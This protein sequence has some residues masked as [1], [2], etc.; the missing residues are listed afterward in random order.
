[1]V[2][3]DPMLNQLTDFLF[4][5]EDDEPVQETRQTQHQSL[6]DKM[7]QFFIEEDY[8]DEPDD[9]QMT[10]PSKPVDKV[11]DH[12]HYNIAHYT[13]NSYHDIDQPA[14][15]LK[16]KHIVILRYHHDNMQRSLDFM[17]GL[18]YTLNAETIQLSKS[19]Y[20]YI[21]EHIVYKRFMV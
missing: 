1:M 17:S 20:L 13:I 6:L 21:P 19:T 15:A 11:I 2:E 10:M 9:I 5:Y 12:D 18:S 7:K 3:V 4:E 16:K 14:M 8:E